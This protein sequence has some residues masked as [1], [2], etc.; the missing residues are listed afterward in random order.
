[1]FNSKIQE[2]TSLHGSNSDIDIKTPENKTYSD[3]MSGYYPGTFGFEDVPDDTTPSYCE[4]HAIGTT[5]DFVTSYTTVINNKVDG[6]GNAHNKVLLLKDGSGSSVCISYLNFTDYGSEIARDGTF[7]FYHGIN[8]AGTH[9]LSRIVLAG[10]HGTLFQIIFDTNALQINYLNGT[11]QYYTGVNLA[12]DRWYRYSI[13]ISCDGGYAGLGSNQF[14]FR[15]YDENDALIYT[16]YDMGFQ[17]PHP[18]GGPNRISMVSSQT[19]TQVYEYMDAFCITGL[20]DGYEI[21]D[22]LEEG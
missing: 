4:Y 2:N 9:Y 5:P 10:N 16:S 22:N 21:G 15:I 19:Q 6:A 14:R 8:L 11:G 1:S 18:T 12:R 13:D 20:Q 7:E 17:D 3:S